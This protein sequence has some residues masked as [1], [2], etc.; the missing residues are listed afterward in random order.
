LSCTAI[1]T[2]LPAVFIFAKDFDPSKFRPTL[3]H[4]FITLLHKK[5]LLRT[6]FTQNIDG[7]E[8]RAHLPVDALVEAH[9]TILSQ[10]CIECKRPADGDKLW[11]SI[12]RGE[13]YYCEE[14][15]H[16]VKPDIVFF[17]EEVGTSLLFAMA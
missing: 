1:H 3:A 13:V 8:R 15:G 4:S 2:A 14:C 10:H 16:P 11:A 7:L 5:G 6:V 9:G 17:G 12:R